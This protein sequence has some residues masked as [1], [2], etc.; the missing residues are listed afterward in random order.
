MAPLV[1]G[2]PAGV[3]ARRDDP[4]RDQRHRGI[5][6]VAE[7]VAGEAV[8]R[9]AVDVDERHE[10]SCRQSEAG[11]AGGGGAPV[12]GVP[13]APGPEA[14][15]DARD[16]ARVWRA[17]VDDDRRHVC[18]ERR[19]AVLELLPL[20]VYGHD[21]HHLA[22]GHARSRWRI[23][24]D[25]AGVEQPA[26]QQPLGTILSSWLASQPAANGAGATLRQRHQPRR[27]AAE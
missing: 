21:D 14:F 6:E 24:L 13:D 20:A 25:E 10:R 18:G 16:R 4:R 9:G 22:A 8:R 27:G 2:D 12:R 19:Q 7:Q 5:L 15:G 17:V 1:R 23:W 26:R 11:V 3:P